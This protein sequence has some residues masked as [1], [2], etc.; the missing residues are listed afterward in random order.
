MGSASGAHHWYILLHLKA[1]PGCR[2]GFTP[3][4][5]IHLGKDSRCGPD[6]ANRL[7]QYAGLQVLRQ[8]TWA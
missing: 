4:V 7:V 1:A 8:C 5:D 2:P 6:G 3:S